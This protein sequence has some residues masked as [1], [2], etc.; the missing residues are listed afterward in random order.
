[1]RVLTLWLIR[2][3]GR[4]TV[5]PFAA[6]IVVVCMIWLDL[7][8]STLSWFLLALTPVVA[9][10]FAA[11]AALAI[12]VLLAG[13]KPDTSG[14][15]DRE[16]ARDLWQL[17]DK[18]QNTG[19]R[20]LAVNDEF[21]ASIQEHRRFAGLFG[22]RVLM[23]IGLP[24]LL[25][26]DDDAVTAVVAHEVGHARHMH[27][28]G[29]YKL[30]DF[31]AAL[32][33]F[34][35]YADPHNTITGALALRAFAWLKRWLDDQIIIDRRCAEFEADA[36]SAEITSPQ[37]AARTLLLVEV[38]GHKLS[39]LYR[40]YNQELLG[41]VKPP[42]SPLLRI[43]DLSKQ[44]LDWNEF[45]TVA[46]EL[47]AQTTDPKSDHPAMR[48]RLRALG[49]DEIMQLHPQMLGSRCSF[50]PPETIERLITDFDARWN[51]VAA[52]QLDYA[53]ARRVHA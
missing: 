49:F 35:E 25:L 1:M 20:V 10:A 44:P 36:V 15:L 29:T 53:G 19:G 48:D 21:N 30:V 41:A 22:R 24:L 31:D 46:R 6:L 9:A 27:I 7:T 33:R 12:G 3:M 52:E 28:S 45:W 26:L 34:F 39:A 8:L 4:Y 13:V 47:H 32:D 51:R 37:L 16:Q 38:Y 42:R 11:T 40:A 23:K 43:R 2:I 5:L 18:F 50:L 17:W 14:S